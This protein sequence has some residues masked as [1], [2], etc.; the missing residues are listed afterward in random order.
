MENSEN[1]LLVND[2]HRGVSLMRKR[3]LIKKRTVTSD[4]VNQTTQ[5]TTNM[6]FSQNYVPNLNQS[7]K[8]AGLSIIDQSNSDLSSPDTLTSPQSKEPVKVQ[9]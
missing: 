7:Q 3:E 6:K 2:K 4:S 5:K 9:R 1:D 8:A